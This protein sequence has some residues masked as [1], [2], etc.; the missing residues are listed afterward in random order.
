MEEVLR[1]GSEPA[2]TLPLL[3]VELIV[4]EMQNRRDPVTLTLALVTLLCFSTLAPF[5]P[6]IMKFDNDNFAH[7]SYTMTSNQS[8]LHDLLRD[9]DRRVW[10]QMNYP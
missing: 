2:P 5:V 10:S 9:S 3:M 8:Y 6:K 1:S 4:R 7:K